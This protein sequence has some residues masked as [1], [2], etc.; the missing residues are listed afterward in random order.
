MEAQNILQ[1]EWLDILF[2]G[3][4]KDYG[5]YN[6][7]KT[8]DKRLKYA[9]IGMS[10][11]CIIACAGMLFANDHHGQINQPPV[12][13]EV[14]L[15][16]TPDKPEK[17]VPPPP[18]KPPKPIQH[19][20]TRIY[21]DRIQVVKEVVPPPPSMKE[22][23]NVQI[24]NE[25]V[26]G[27]KGGDIIAPPIEAGTTKELQIKTDDDPTGKEVF[28]VQIQAKFPGGTDAWMNF[29][30]RNL[31]AS[32]PVDNGAPAGKYT[33]V[34]SFLVDAEGNISEVEALNDPGYGTANEAVRVIKHSN[35]W[36]PAVQNGRNVIYRQKQ[37][38]TFEVAD[39]N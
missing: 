32:L 18:P 8:Y 39:D 31:N 7:R 4:N 1:A 16:N 35:K 11:V 27:E 14:T 22:L 33:V 12:W 17:P 21:V 19:L 29:L 5:A 26:H 24:G 36:L 30:R 34:V 23:E 25:N 6:L 15:A 38:I 37:G 28:I 2:D 3:K 13:T 9:L 20:E 10:T